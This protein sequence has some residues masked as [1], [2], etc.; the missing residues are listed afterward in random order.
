MVAERD[1]D[2]PVDRAQ[3]FERMQRRHPPLGG[4]QHDALF[5]RRI[6]RPEA[7]GWKGAFDRV[8]AFAPEQRTAGIAL[9]GEG[10]AFGAAERQ[11]ALAREAGFRIGIGVA[12]SNVGKGGPAADRDRTDALAGVE[13]KPNAAGAATDGDYQENQ[14]QEERA[15]HRRAEAG[16]PEGLAC[17]AGWHKGRRPRQTG[18]EPGPTAPLKARTGSPDAAALP[19]A[20]CDGRAATGP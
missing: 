15:D 20:A 1:L 11:P 6:E 16:G 4:G 3:H 5:V 14:D 7:G 9:R 13:R 8:G 12:R 2:R 19:S 17:R 10:D 18:T